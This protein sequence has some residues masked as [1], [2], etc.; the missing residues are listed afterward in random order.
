MKHSPLLFLALSF[1]TTAQV[2]V[3]EPIE[4]LIVRITASQLA[5]Q[6]YTPRQ[7]SVN[8]NINGPYEEEA[9]DIWMISVDN[10]NFLSGPH[11]APITTE[12]AFAVVFPIL[13][14]FP[15]GTYEVYTIAQGYY[16]PVRASYRFNVWKYP[17]W[18]TPR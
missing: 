14:N 11:S 13:D 17:S 2:S 10:P 3:A 15:A 8:G 16:G 5:T 12:G 1:L 6:Q 4:P 7:I 18:P 9:L